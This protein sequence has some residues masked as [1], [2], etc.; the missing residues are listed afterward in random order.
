[1]MNLASRS[2]K[3]LPPVTL[4]LFNDV[5]AVAFGMT[6]SLLLTPDESP[7]PV[8]EDLSTMLVVVSALV[9][10][11]GLLS[12]V[13]GYQSVSV[14]AVASIAGYVSVPLSYASQVFMFG[15]MPDRWST[16]GTFL[17]C[18]INVA[19]TVQKWRAMSAA[20]KSDSDYARLPHSCDGTEKA[21]LHVPSL[22]DVGVGA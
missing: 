7:F 12:N 19:A 10:W 11:V 18:V 6:W 1:M 3:D 16:V 14:S 20:A 22:K 17:I 5:V 2:L 21:D 9:G 4:C 8:S 15:Q 13:K